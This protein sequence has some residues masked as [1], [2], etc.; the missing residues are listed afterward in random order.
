MAKEKRLNIRVGTKGTKQT[1][2]RLG[3]VE[4]GMSSL[5]KKALMAGGAFFAAQGI[6]RGMKAAVDAAGIQEQAEKKLETALGHTNKKLLEQASAFQKQS[7]HGDETIISMMALASNMGIAEDKLSETTQMAIGLSEALGVD[8]NMAMKAAAGAIQGDTNM[9]TRYI[10][11]LKMTKDATEKLSIVQR[12]AN[13]GFKQSE[14]DTKTMAGAVNQAKMALGDMGEVLGGIFAPLVTKGAGAMQIF[15][16]EMGKAFK[17]IGEIDFKETGSNILKNGDAL[18]KAFIAT[19]KVY[20]DL[21][22]DHFRIIFGK[23]IPAVKFVFTRLLDGI[24][25]I[26]TLIWDPLKIGLEIVSGKIKNVFIGMFNFV[27]EQFNNM[28]GLLGKLGV[29]IAPLT[30]T[31]LVDTESLSVAD[32][33]IG[34]FFTSL[35]E[36]N[37]QTHGQAATAIADIWTNYANTIIE[38]NEEVKDNLGVDE[39][40]NTKLPGTIT[41]A[42]VEEQVSFFEQLSTKWVDA[43]GNMI[44]RTKDQEK[45]INEQKKAFVNNMQTIASEFPGAEKAA[46]RFAQV[47]AT[48]DAIAA[49]NAAYKAMAGIP[50]VGPALGIAAAA[51]ALGAGYAN[52]K[53]IEAAATGYDDIVNSPTMFLAG[54]AGA[55]RVSVTPLEGPNINGPQGGSVNITFTGNVTSQEFI[56]NDAIPQIKEAIRRGADIGVG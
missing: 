24:K 56:E 5:A 14:A 13:K 6:V 50:V 28:T 52:V 49:A 19:I 20:L 27:K 17:F 55:E 48:V 21:M 32:T 12:A 42:Q 36:D 4:K 31:D 2:K 16:E 53:K 37:I 25:A 30:L 44:K 41:E 38:K 18:M 46:K 51:A 1:K 7:K 8:M 35:G 43:S 29:D 33:A 45:A 10:P 47:Q 3:G 11:E 15:A 26:A 34:Q 54:E 9:L 23:I 22:P 40:G 39:N